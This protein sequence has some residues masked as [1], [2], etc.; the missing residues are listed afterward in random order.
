MPWHRQFILAALAGTLIGALAALPA[1]GD[2]RSAGR[3]EFSV[4]SPQQASGKATPRWA[5]VVLRNTADSQL[6]FSEQSP[7]WDYQIEIPGTDGS[8]IELTY[9]GKCVLPQPGTLLRNIL[10]KLEPGEADH[11]ES[12]ELTKLFKLIRI[13]THRISVRR[14]VW[15]VPGG[16]PPLSVEQFL[17]DCRPPSTCA[18]HL[19]L[20]STTATLS[21]TFPYPDLSLS[22][23]P[24]RCR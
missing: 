24:E 21:I 6:F 18:S 16:K 23:G 17:S 2:D 14:W 11:L 13:G 9:Y 5:D 7:D 3:I 10:R 19:L 22:A 12:V 1:F 15:Q 20:P 8:P 4:R